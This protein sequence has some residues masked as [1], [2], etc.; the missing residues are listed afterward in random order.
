MPCSTDEWLWGWDPT[1]G[2]VSVWAES[3]GRANVWRRISGRLIHEDASYR[4]W[5]LLDRRDDI[6]T[7]GSITV[8][9][10]EGPGDLRFL[11]SADDAKF[12]TSAILQAASQRLGR[13]VANL[14]DLGKESVLAPFRRA[15]P[16]YHRPHLLPRPLFRPTP[17]PAIRPRNHRPRSRPQPHLHDRRARPHWRR[18]GPRSAWRR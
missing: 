18:G 16:G 15:I 2:I 7:D 6:P 4:P 1:P 12:L 3:D 9:E 14:R 8:R 13:R 10:L 5:V 11:V 17:P